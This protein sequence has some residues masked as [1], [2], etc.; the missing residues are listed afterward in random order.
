MIIRRLVASYAS[1]Y[2]ALMLDAYALHPDAFT[3]SVAE[4]AA[5][6]ITWWASRLAGGPDSSQ[7]VVGI[8]KDD[9]LAGA[10]GLS[11]EPREKVMHKATLFGMYV[12]AKF[13]RQGLGRGL[14][15]SVLAEAR[16]R[17]GVRVVQL[18]VTHGNRDAH[19]L[20][21]QCG[22]VEFGW[23]PFAVNMGTGFASKVHMWCD[24]LAPHDNAPA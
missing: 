16:A 21:T 6:P 15:H 12:Q 9:E 11:F 10:A 4:R 22:F 19:A 7:L 14:V 8:F 24:L 1:A 2:R 20:Y 13:R 23:E 5:L 18:T 3:S 17:T